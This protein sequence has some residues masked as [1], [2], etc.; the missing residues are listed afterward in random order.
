MRIQWRNFLTGRDDATVFN[1]SFLSRPAEWH[2]AAVGFGTGVLTALALAF[3]VGQL[4]TIL[5]TIGGSSLVGLGMLRTLR[6]SGHWGDV[7]REPAYAAGAAFLGLLVGMGIA[8]WLS[9]LSL[10]GL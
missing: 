8:T 3:G 10:G 1:V 6:Q 5:V 4:H 2:A 9:F 7:M